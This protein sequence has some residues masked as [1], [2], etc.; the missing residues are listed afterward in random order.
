MASSSTERKLNGLLDS[1]SDQE[2]DADLSPPVETFNFPSSDTCWVCNGY[3]GPN[4]DEPLCGTCH[5][6]LYP[7]NP[8]EDFLTT[9]SDD[10]DSGNDEPPFNAADKEKQEEADEDAEDIDPEELPSGADE[11]EEE[12]VEVVPN[13]NNKDN[14]NVALLPI[15]RPHP[16]APRNLPHFMQML[17]EPR[18]VDEEPSE[19]KITSLPVEMMVSIFSYLDDM[20]MWKA[21]EVCKQW[22]NIL[23]L[24]TSQLMWKK[25]LKERWPLFQSIIE[26]PNWLQMYSALMSSCFCRTC[27]LQMA[28]KSPPRA[29]ENAIRMNL[30][31]NDFRLLNSYASE[32]IEAIPLDKQNTYWQ[33]SILGP[34]GSPYEGGKFFLYIFFPE[35]YPMIPP[36]VRF[37][38]KILHPNV[39]RHGDVGIDIIQHNWSLALTV[40]KLLL[41]VQSLLTDP[42]TE[43]CME[44]QLGHMYEHDRRR[45]ENLA[46]SWTWQYAMFEVIPPR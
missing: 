2:G 41:S 40:S 23:E 32:G 31:R 29:R 17:S 39:S 3:Y 27:L 24:N 10:E 42:F 5:S 46:R 34:A 35:T 4:F 13:D 16:T 6:F 7:T 22:R 1:L 43:V 14:P 30:L 26:V 15:Q 20:S 36:T 18:P 28:L 44:P 33:A 21:S 8:A 11:E 45:F 37:L 12:E 38:T 9:L 19:K 25:Y